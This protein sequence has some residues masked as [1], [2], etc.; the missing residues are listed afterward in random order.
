[1]KER[2]RRERQLEEERIAQMNR[3][4]VDAPSRHRFRSICILL[5]LSRISG[6]SSPLLWNI[7]C[8]RH[9]HLVRKSED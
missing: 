8:M 3:D 6:C 9:S 1:M 5:L 2:L 7:Q 4:E